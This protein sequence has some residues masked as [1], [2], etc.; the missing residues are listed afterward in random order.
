[1]QTIHY[2]LAHKKDVTPDVLDTWR[3]G[4]CRLLETP[5]FDVRVTLGTE[6]YNR[7]IFSLGG[8]EAWTYDVGR[9]RLAHGGPAFV[10]AVVP[11]TD[12]DLV[13]KA[14]Y[15]ILAGFRDKYRFAYFPHE[16]KLIP[17]TGVQ[18]V[19]RDDFIQHAQIRMETAP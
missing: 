12:T 19:D 2:F 3:A 1:M 17:I 11:I 15:Q 9:R 18:V 8:W 16:N 4:L 10:G 13:G 7:Y 6:D 5:G 14:T